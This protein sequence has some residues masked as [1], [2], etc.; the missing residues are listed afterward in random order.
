[1]NAEPTGRKEIENEKLSGVLL[2]QEEQPR[3]PRAHIRQREQR[4]GRL[5]N[6]QRAG[7]GA[8]RAQRLPANDESTGR[9][10]VRE[11]SP[12]CG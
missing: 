9:E 11:P 2:D 3:I 5:P 12:F 7:Q 10:P 4:E 8:D 6:L 1:M